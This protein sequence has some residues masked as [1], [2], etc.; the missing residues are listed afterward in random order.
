MTDYYHC[1]A[2]TSTNANTTDAIIKAIKKVK[3]DHSDFVAFGTSIFSCNDESLTTAE[4]KTAIWNVFFQTFI[5]VIDDSCRV[6]ED[7]IE[8]IQNRLGADFFSDF[9]NKI[10][11]IVNEIKNRNYKYDFE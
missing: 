4:I 3:N 2:I 7:V 6:S 8:Y 1:T 10:T 5:N 11:S 9:D